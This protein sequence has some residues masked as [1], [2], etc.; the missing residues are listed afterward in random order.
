[1]SIFKRMFPKFFLKNKVIIFEKRGDAIIQR[2]GF[3]RIKRDKKEGINKLEMAY[4][5]PNKWLMDVITIE[6]PEYSQYIL[7]HKG[8]PVLM[9]A[10]P[11]LGDF[12]ALTPIIFTTT[13]KKPV[14][15][16]SKEVIGE[17]DYYTEGIHLTCRDEGV[18]FW[19]LQ[20]V[21]KYRER[22][23]KPT[24]MEKYGNLIFSTTA[25]GLIF[26]M[27]IITSK[28][29][30]SMSSELGGIA[31]AVKQAAEIFRDAASQIKGSAI[32]PPH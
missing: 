11:T 21:K 22:Y 25:M 6:P 9:F 10:S 13:Q 27:I 32:I 15:N 8:K 14:Y 2:N 20:E 5:V 16:E 1:M 31:S 23:W 30:V 7:D 3:G 28:N 19:S 18:S 29:M 4:P 26:L 24:F 17:Q 12:R